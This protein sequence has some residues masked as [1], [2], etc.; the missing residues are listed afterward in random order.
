MIHLKEIHKDNLTAFLKLEVHEN[1]KDQ[2]A[3]NAISIAQGNYSDKAWFR[4]IYRNDTPVGFVM[5]S[6]D[7]EKKTYWVHRYMI[8]K[9]HQGK[10]YGKAALIQIIE[11]MKTIPD[12]EEIILTYVPKKENGANLFYEKLGFVDTGI[13]YKNTGEI[14]MK[15]KIK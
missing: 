4:G 15:L 10:G 11:F 14:L 8:D 2:V 13:D 3:T 5:L 7:Y 12:I 9:N 1:Q 6:L